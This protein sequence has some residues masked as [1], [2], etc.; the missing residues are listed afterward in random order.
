MNKKIILFGSGAYGLRVLQALEK[1][2]VYAFCDNPVKQR[3]VDMKYHILQLT[4]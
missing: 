4:I 2:N 1:K 3:G